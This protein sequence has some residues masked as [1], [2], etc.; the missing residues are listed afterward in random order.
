M[1]QYDSVL[2]TYADAGMRTMEDW[3]TTGREVISGSAARANAYHRGVQM[4]LFTRDQTHIRGKAM[5]SNN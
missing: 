5:E 4:E 3:A 1:N 2:R